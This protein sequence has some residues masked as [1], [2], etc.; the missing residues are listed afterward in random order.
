MVRRAHA[1]QMLIFSGFSS[2]MLEG[3]LDPLGDGGRS[4]A[5]PDLLRLAAERALITEFLLD[6]VDETEAVAAGPALRRA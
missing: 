1:L 3:L 2:F 5:A 6:L 4:A